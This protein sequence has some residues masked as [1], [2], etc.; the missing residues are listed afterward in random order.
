MEPP[1]KTHSY[2][3]AG[4]A[5]LTL[6]CECLGATWALCT[7]YNSAQDPVAFFRTADMPGVTPSTSTWTKLGTSAGGI[8]QKSSKACHASA[9]S[10]PIQLLVCPSCRGSHG[11]GASDRSSGIP[12]AQ[13]TAGLLH[14]HRLKF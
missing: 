13:F 12:R 4:L 5:I 11:T 6:Y 8:G 3:V 2:R 10:F 7:A 1:N 14:L 9:P